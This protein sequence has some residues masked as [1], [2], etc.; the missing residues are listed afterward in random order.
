MTEENTAPDA[1]PATEKPVKKKSKP[2]IIAGITF[3]FL[4]V[5]LSA[6]VVS[7]LTKPPLASNEQI[8]NFYGFTPIENPNFDDDQFLKINET[9]K[10]ID[11]CERPT[12]TD[13]QNKTDLK[14]ETPL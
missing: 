2:I 14:C 3:L 7:Q 9:N 13:A 4:A 1:E 8:Q 11:V 12:V 6:Q 10:M 5:L